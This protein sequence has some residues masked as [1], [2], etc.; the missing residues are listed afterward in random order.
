MKTPSYWGQGVAMREVRNDK[1]IVGLQI[2]KSCLL[3]KELE[4]RS[5][6]VMLGS[7]VLT[8]FSYQFTRWCICFRK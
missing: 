1:K 6:N 8:S 5:V 4:F 2:I 7:A 3:G